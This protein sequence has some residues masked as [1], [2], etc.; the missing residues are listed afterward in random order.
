MLALLTDAH[1]SPAVAEQINARRPEID[2]HSLREWRG[3]A[4]LQAEDHSILTAAMEEGR[5]LITYDQRTIAPLLLQWNRGGRSHSGVIFINRHTIAQSD[6]G[7]QVRG[8]AALWDATH[9][10]DWTNAVAYLK[11]DTG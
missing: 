11:E 8:L 3:G 4:L 6:I 5:S 1:I 10:Q 9:T 2:I 7:A